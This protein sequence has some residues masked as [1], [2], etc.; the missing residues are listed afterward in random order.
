VADAAGSGSGPGLRDRGPSAI[1]RPLAADGGG[2]D[3]V[4]DALGAILQGHAGHDGAEA[5]RTG[6]GGRPAPAPGVLGGF[7]TDAEWL[8]CR[9]GKARPVEPGIEPLVDGITKRM[10]HSGD[11]GVPINANKT[12]EARVMRLR[13]YGNAIVAPVA[14]EFIRAFLDENL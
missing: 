12:A 6:P 14:I 8:P 5:R 4:G 2:S 1:G 9:D 10:G 11:N 13:G 7:W 3:L